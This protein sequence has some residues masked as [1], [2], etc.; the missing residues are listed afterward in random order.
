MVVG[1][2]PAA[3]SVSTPEA[4][5]P[6]Q[7]LLGQRLY[8]GLQDPVTAQCPDTVASPYLRVGGKLIQGDDRV[9]AA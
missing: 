1:V 5:S 9:A 8:L 4:V 3:G 2:L 7:R 6:W